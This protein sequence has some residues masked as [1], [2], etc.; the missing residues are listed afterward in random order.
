MNPPIQRYMLKSIQ[1]ILIAALIIV[2]FPSLSQDKAA[3]A[4]QQPA[5]QETSQKL[6]LAEGYHDL[7]TLYLSKGDVDRA[8]AEARQIAQLRLPAEYEK[9]IAQSLSIITEKFAQARRF[10]L[11]QTLLDDALKSTEQSV[12]KVKILRNKARLYMLSGE[13]D[14]AIESWRR[15]LDI[16]SRRSR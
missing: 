3:L 12:N 11:G 2:A 13:N 8:F 9:L 7:A 5:D 16:E 15:A 4:T 10:D 1:C 6:I 14:K